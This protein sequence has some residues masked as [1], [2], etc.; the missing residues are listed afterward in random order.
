VL[1][2]HRGVNAFPRQGLFMTA[3]ILFEK[4]N[5]VAWIT[6][7]R[8]AARNAFTPPMCEQLAN[9][10]RDLKD[11]G[12]TR[13]V[14]LRASG[15][16]FSVGADLKAMSAGL[17][18]VGAERG[19]DIPAIARATAVPLV[20]G[21]YALRQPIIASVRGHIIGI[22]AQLALSADLCVASETSKFLLPQVRLAHPVDHGESF[23]LPRKIGP[24][25]AMQLLLLA[26]TLRADQARDYGLV[27]W[28]VADADLEAKT[29]E[30]VQKL[31][32][33]A[34]VAAAE[35]KALLYRSLAN[36]LDQQCEAEMQSLGVCA[37]TDDFPE[38]LRAFV[39]KRTPVFRG[40]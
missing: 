7:N 33:V 32:A 37:A 19:R 28:L 16:D 30:I 34:P 3:E 17:S 24:A 18:P 31:Q 27:N 22:G 5:G 15:T 25:R 10:V 1:F 36:T 29:A 8:P 35:I 40:R 21:L 2:S 14:V 9:I 26:E 38:A 12:A 23:F 11:D 4:H 6:L 20:T 39:E 13:V